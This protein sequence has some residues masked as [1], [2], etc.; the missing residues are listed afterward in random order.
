MAGPLQAEP[1]VDPSLMLLHGDSVAKNI[2]TR[3]SGRLQKAAFF[4]LLRTL[5]ILWSVPHDVSSRRLRCPSTF[6]PNGS[7]SAESVTCSTPSLLRT[8]PNTRLQH[9]V[10]GSTNQLPVSPSRRRRHRLREGLSGPL[11]ERY[12]TRP[13]RVR[14][15]LPAETGSLLQASLDLFPRDARHSATSVS[16]AALEFVAVIDRDPRSGF[17]AVEQRCG[18]IFSLCFGELHGFFEGLSRRHPCAK[19]SAESRDGFD[20]TPSTRTNIDATMPAASSSLRSSSTRNVSP[21]SSVPPSSPH[22]AVSL[23]RMSN[24][25]PSPVCVRATTEM[26]TIG[27]RQR[28]PRHF[29]DHAKGHLGGQPRIITK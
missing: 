2:G 11:E 10:P 28:E 23:R 27:R 24:V 1:F 20:H 21:H 6:S 16:R 5:P 14:V 25:R 8:M 19:D 17:E 13:R 4:P 15:R 18:E 22:V 9:S 3:R 12:A 26:P 7:Q 29:V